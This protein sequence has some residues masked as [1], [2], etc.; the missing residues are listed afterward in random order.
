MRKIASI[1]LAAAVGLGL[2]VAPPATAAVG[3][4]GSPIWRDEF[5]GTSVNPSWTLRS[6]TYGSGNREEHRYLPR[7]AV[8]SSG[9]LKIITKKEKTY[10]T[11]PAVS[12]RAPDG[13]MYAKPRTGVPANVRYYTSAFLDTRQKGKYFPLYS[14][15]EI[16]ARLPHGQGLLPAFWLRRNMGG[17]S[18]AE[19]DILEYF[20]NHKP[21]YGKFTLHFPAT[22]GHNVTQ[23]RAWFETPVW[24]T[25]GWHTWAIEITPAGDPSTGPVNFSWYL[26]GTLRGFYQVKDAATLRKLREVPRDKAWDMALNTAVGGNWVGLPDQ[27]VGY[28]PLVNR[29]SKSQKA[30]VGGYC[31]KAGL[32]YA[33]MYAKP[34]VFQVD[35]VRVYSRKF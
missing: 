29:C 3:D 6:D 35:Y 15:F 26:D 22:L 25:G 17:A 32:F 13:K 24:G 14:R 19:V 18:Q 27:Q 33:P 21:G 10:G 31:D 23:K 11:S 2:L 5:A 28:L 7:N 34:S 30:P 4:W 16:R 8:V 9:T 20:Y 12:Y 1:L